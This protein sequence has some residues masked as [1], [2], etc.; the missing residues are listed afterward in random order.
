MSLLN[1]PLAFAKSAQ[2]SCQM[3]LLRVLTNPAG[4]PNSKS[5]YCNSLW[6]AQIP[7]C[8]ILCRLCVA[9]CF[10]RWTPSW[11]FGWS[12]WL[13]S[14]GLTLQGSP[15]GAQAHVGAA[16]IGVRARAA[17]MCAVPSASAPPAQPLPCL[18]LC[19]VGASG[20]VPLLESL[21]AHRGVWCCCGCKTVLR[22]PSKILRKLWENTGSTQ[23]LKVPKFYWFRPGKRLFQAGHFSLQTQIYSLIS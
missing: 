14:L 9:L 22:Q 10:H 18:L 17:G 7:Y 1:L 21:A 16:S 5:H 8:K 23:L 11:G 6:G 13:V 2:R 15:D 4:S 3:F 20:C 19:S 12:S